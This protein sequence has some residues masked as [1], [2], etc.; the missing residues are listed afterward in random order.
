MSDGKW[1]LGPPKL[2]VAHA[3][4]VQQ[5]QADAVFGTDGYGTVFA[6]DSVPDQVTREVLRIPES[7]SLVCL[8]P[9][10]VPESWPETPPKKALEEFIVRETF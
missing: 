9:I 7:Y 8:T 10:G 4:Q 5:R 2:T 1:D 6:T 3:G